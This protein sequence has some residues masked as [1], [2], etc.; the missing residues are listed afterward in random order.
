MIPVPQLAT[1]GVFKS[2]RS[3][4][5]AA[6][7]ERISV[8]DFILFVSASRSEKNGTHFESGTRP[9]RTPGLS[10]GAAPAHRGV[11][12][13]STNLSFVLEP[14]HRS[15]TS[16][17]DRTD[18][19]SNVALNF[20][21]VFVFSPRLARAAAFT[22]SSVTG[23]TSIA[24]PSDSQPGTP[25]SSTA[26]AQCPNTLNIHHALAALN[27][28]APSYTTTWSPFSMPSASH[29]EAK[30]SALGNMCGNDESGS[31]I[32]STSKYRAP[33]MRQM[34]CS[35]F[36]SRPIAGRYHEQS[37]SL[38]SAAFSAS[39]FAETMVVAVEE[40]LDIVDIARDRVRPRGKR[41]SAR[42][43]TDN[44]QTRC[45]AMLW[46][47]KCLGRKQ[48]ISRPK[49]DDETAVID[50]I[51]SCRFEHAARTLER[52]T[53]MAAAALD[54]YDLAI[55]PGFYRRP[56]ARWNEDGSCAPMA[57]ARGPK[58]EAFQ[59]LIRQ[60]DIDDDIAHIEHEVRVWLCRDR[61]NHVTNSRQ[62]DTH[63]H[64]TTRTARS[65]HVPASHPTRL[66]VADP[67]FGF[68][69]R[70]RVPAG[71]SA[72]QNQITALLTSSQTLPPPDRHRQETKEE[73][74]ATSSETTQGRITPGGES[75]GRV[76][77]GRLQGR[78]GRG[79]RRRVTFIPFVQSVICIFAKSANLFS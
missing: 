9:L 32:L 1:S 26:T 56:M 20:G 48:V 38:T 58:G 51:L 76:S 61:A 4:P 18:A 7:V 3:T 45:A 73:E 31:L 41:G 64:D 49:L 78:E 16:C 21:V 74:G 70:R 42:G 36:A 35:C 22:T 59:P 68:S 47:S 71:V 33:G 44:A 60:S 52:T 30:D 75:G 77:Q 50:F 28:P 34:A 17:F 19:A 13:A 72:D 6:N 54:E 11:G 5:A 29:A 14:T 10:S 53:T 79:S 57:R 12:R 63:A 46:P 43:G 15:S 55:Y 66:L 65:G 8:F 40:A 69:D 25:P 39:H 27:S 67:I 23:V 37:K 62:L 24:M 2:Q